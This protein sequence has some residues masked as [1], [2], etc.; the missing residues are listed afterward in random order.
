VH[1]KLSRFI[2]FKVL[3]LSTSDD[4][5]GPLFSALDSV[6]FISIPSENGGMIYPWKFYESC[7]KEAGFETIERIHFDTWSPHGAILAKKS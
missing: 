6:Y 4:E 2:K 5:S 7:L 1:F 3:T